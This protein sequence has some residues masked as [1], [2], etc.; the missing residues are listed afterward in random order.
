MLSKVFN[1]DKQKN[2]AV[3]TVVKKMAALLNRTK[4]QHSS[5]L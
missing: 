2:S 3:L 5:N 1:K 4:K